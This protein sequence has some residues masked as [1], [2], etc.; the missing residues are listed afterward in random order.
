MVTIKWIA[1]YCGHGGM[2]YI[3][4]RDSTDTLQY[5]IVVD[6]GSN[7]DRSIGKISLVNYQ[8]LYDL[9]WVENPGI[10]VI[11]CI[12]HYDED[13]YNFF[14]SMYSKIIENAE[15]IEKIYFGSLTK[16]SFKAL[17]PE[18]FV[19]KVFHLLKEKVSILDQISSTDSLVKVEDAEFGILWNNL[20][21]NRG[22][23]DNSAAYYLMNTTTYHAYIFTGDITGNTYLALKEDF[24]D[25]ESEIHEKFQ[26]YFTIVTVPHHGSINTLLEGGFIK[27]HDFN[28]RPLIDAMNRLSLSGGKFILSTGVKDMFRHP[29]NI[30]AKT[31]NAIANQENPI[32]V[33]C[34]IFFT[35]ALGRKKNYKCWY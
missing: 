26:D 16:D 14:D 9:L 28:M 1:F 30:A 18:A 27:I 20:C 23:N 7:D 12:T 24:E 21:K 32:N 17:A 10:P 35:Y 5:K 25:L 19:K 31:F 15:C 22:V 29:D 2:N 11:L 34:P 33:C 3:E 13:H 4:I 6:A 8:T